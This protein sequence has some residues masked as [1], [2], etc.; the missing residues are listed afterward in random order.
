MKFAML[1]LGLAVVTGT[2]ARTPAEKPPPPPLQHPTMGV[3]NGCFVE[4]VVF[5]DAFQEKY[6]PTAWVR[7]LQWGATEEEEVVA[8]HAVAVCQVRDR[9]WCW[10]I[11]SGFS[12]L[13][14]PPALREN[15]EKVAAPILVHYPKIS[16]YAPLYR[17]EF[18]QAPDPAPPTARLTE[19]DL[20]VRDATVAAARLARHRPVNVVG[21]TY[22]DGEGGRRRS[23]AAVFVFNGR[24]CIY[25]PEYG[26]VPFRVRGSLKNLRLIQELLRRMFPGAFEVRPL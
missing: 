18:P 5:S 20:A 26:T 19:T 3:E 11:N 17:R 24:Y 9:L 7:L 16:A 14:V 2:E 4:S 25:A 23:A 15:V 22:I 8:G 13:P 12:V 10:D 6:G 21:F 1:W